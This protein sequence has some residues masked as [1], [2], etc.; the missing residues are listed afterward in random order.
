MDESCGWQLVRIRVI[1]I[2]ESGGPENKRRKN[3]RKTRSC[4]QHFD[5]PVAARVLRLSKE[6]LYRSP[7]RLREPRES[8]SPVI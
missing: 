7:V 4:R 8:M 5:A 3:G 6:I 2:I 1:L